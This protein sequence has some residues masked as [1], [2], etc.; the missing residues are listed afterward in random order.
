MSRV[1]GDGDQASHAVNQTNVEK[2]CRWIL[3]Q[4]RSKRRVR[5]E[6]FESAF[7][8][9]DG[10]APAKLR[11]DWSRAIRAVAT[12]LGELRVP[13][14]VLNSGLK[15]NGELEPARYT[16]KRFRPDD[17]FAAKQ[18]IGDL[19][20]S[21][22]RSDKSGRVS[23]FLG[24]GSTI[25]HVGLKMREHGP[26]EQRLFWT[27]NIALA[28]AWCESEEPPVDKIS[29]PEA[30]LE[31]KTFRFATMREP[32]W[33]AAMVIVGADGCF[34]NSEEQ[35]VTLYANEE[36]VAKNTDLFVNHATHTV[37]VC[38]ASKKIGFDRNAGPIIHPPRKGVIRALVT[39]QRPHQEI[40]NVFEREGWTIVTE[41]KD[42]AA[43]PEPKPPVEI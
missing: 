9:S 11:P 22:L 12:T 40:A 14:E 13:V 19:V 21:F 23:V 5:F 16:T 43:L 7:A 17:E 4:L 2:Q 33:A 35:T 34:Y 38:L 30:V 37:M 28:A 25:Y 29:I 27:V 32:G 42:W 41:E 31:T 8:G 39:D 1:N 6:E 15:L 20:A 26:Y 18:K 3:E 36:S 24:S 10:A